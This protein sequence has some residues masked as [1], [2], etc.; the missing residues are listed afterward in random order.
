M[1]K[2]VYKELV[3]EHEDLMTRYEQL[4]EE[5]ESLRDM[6]AAVADELGDPYGE[7][8]GDDPRDWELI[9]KLEARV[10]HFLEKA[11]VNW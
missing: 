4:V 10:V 3:R 5:N 7:N 1:S 6:L 2:G 8:W 11:Y 9:T